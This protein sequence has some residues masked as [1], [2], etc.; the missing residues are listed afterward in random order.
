MTEA[1]PASP[2]DARL[3]GSGPKRMLAL[4]GGGVRGI[5]AVAFLERLEAL[6]AERHP[7]RRPIR[8]ADYFD[9]IGGT[10]TGAIIATALALG[11]TAAEIK[12]FYF[13]LAPKVFR[14]T[15][16]RLAWVQPLFDARP[17]LREIVAQVGDRTL[18]SPDLLTGLVV[19][20]KRMDTGSPWILSNIPGTAFWDTPADGE[21]LGNRHYP[22]A[23]ILRA[24]TAAPHYF[25]PQKI[26]VAESEPP[27]W[28][29]DGGVSPYNNPGLALL[30]VAT[31]RAYRLTWPTGPDKLLMISVGTGGQA[32]RTPPGRLRR[33]T[34][35]GLAVRAL[36]GV[37]ADGQALA[38]TLLQALSRPADP[39]PVNSEIG[40]LEAD[41]LGGRALFS[42][43]RYD[44]RLDGDWIEE[45]T[46]IAVGKDALRNLRRL[47]FAPGAPLAYRIAAAAADRQVRPAHFPAA[48]DLPPADAGA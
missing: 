1:P 7:D 31:L 20:V 8:L 9:L 15:F 36:S 27:G 3:F 38:L 19:V 41:L 12:Q 4:D 34:S 42:F 30:Q 32:P 40:A 21:F 45:Q 29:I 5:V 23:R 24:S 22:L 39:W 35:A 18:D 25:A 11:M 47:D 14:R 17:L 46:G 10:S 28:F 26:A 16:W 2:R 48:F 33:L 37:V 13:D 44:V 6:L 43:Q